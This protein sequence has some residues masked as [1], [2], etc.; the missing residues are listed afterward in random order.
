MLKYKWKYDDLTWEDYYHFLKNYFKCMDEVNN[1]IVY[2][3][4]IARTLE[5]DGIMEASYWRILDKTT[6]AIEFFPF[7][8]RRNPLSKVN[9]TAAS[10]QILDEYF[11][12]LK[13]IVDY[14]KVKKYI[15]IHSNSLY[16]LFYNRRFNLERDWKIRE[17]RKNKIKI[18]YGRNMV[19]S[20][21]IILNQFL[22][23]PRVKIREIRSVIHSIIQ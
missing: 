4:I 19:K 14:L 1:D 13:E 7:R 21:I 20:K 18:L 17:I 16:E 22:M 10:K 15:L 3:K 8:S 11:N 2:F 6:L 23:R 9:L 5:P 12:Q